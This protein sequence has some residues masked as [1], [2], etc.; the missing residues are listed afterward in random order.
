MLHLVA[1]LMRNNR[2]PPPPAT[3]VAFLGCVTVERGERGEH[4]MLS[5]TD[6][7]WE[8][9]YLLL[10]SAPCAVRQSE[11]SYHPPC[12]QAHQ[13]NLG[14]LPFY[15]LLCHHLDMCN[16]R[17]VYLQSG[18]TLTNARERC[19]HTSGQGQRTA[20]LS[21]TPKLFANPHPT[22]RH[23]VNASWAEASYVWHD[24]NYQRE[25]PG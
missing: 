16:V 20:G 1:K 25:R 24:R 6:Y 5:A 3:P 18:Q 19:V 12:H 11:Q 14:I 9:C 23:S 17:C 8:S 13:S 21:Y 7:L 22:V 10:V 4:N 15:V 2:P